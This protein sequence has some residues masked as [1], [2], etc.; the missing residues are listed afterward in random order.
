MNYDARI[1]FREL[2]K[3]AIQKKTNTLDNDG[4]YPLKENKGKLIPA[5]LTKYTPKR[6]KSYEEI[7]KICK[8][9]NINLIAITTPICAQ[10]INREYFNQIKLIYPEIR[11][12]HDTVRD[13]KYFSTCGHMNKAGATEFT[14]IIFNAFFNSKKIE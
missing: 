13:D 8:E 1:G 5:D 10:T 12:F 4:F 11:N 9:N 6:N 14:K 3:T 2:F 7:K